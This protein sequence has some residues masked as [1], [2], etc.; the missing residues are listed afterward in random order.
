[1]ANYRRGYRAELAAKKELEAQGFTVLRAAGS[2]GPF[3]LVAFNK[4]V[5]RF[6]Q[7]KR[8]RNGS[9][10]L[11][12]SLRELERVPVPPCAR[13]EVWLWRDKEGF[14]EREAVPNG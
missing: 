1:M 4:D 8:V 2:K 10:G 14:A 6:I 7:V 13:K 3:D 5:V 9:G 12:K 11:S